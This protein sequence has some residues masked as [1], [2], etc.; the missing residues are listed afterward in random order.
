[1]KYGVRSRRSVPLT[2]SSLFSLWLTEICPEGRTL[3][4]SSAQVVGSK[5]ELFFKKSPLAEKNL[6]TV[7]LF[8]TE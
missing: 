2:H 8:I 4:T 7:N 5:I 6:S 3:F 1:M